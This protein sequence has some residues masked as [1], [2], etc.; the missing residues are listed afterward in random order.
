M[1]AALQRQLAAWG[2]SPQSPC[3]LAISGGLDSRVLLALLLQ[4][5][6]RP[7][8]AHAHF[9]LRGAEAEADA[10]FVQALA[11][12]HG[13]RFHLQHFETRAFAQ[14]QGLSIQMAARQLRYRF[15]AELQQAQGYAAVFTAHHADDHIETAL[16]NWSRAASLPALAGIPSQRDFYYRPLLPFRRQALKDYALAKGLQW[17]EDRS[18]QSLDYQRNALRHQVIPT[19]RAVDPQFERAFLRSLDYLREQYGALSALLDEKLAQYRQRER[20][21]ERLDFP[22]ALAGAAYAKALLRYWLVP[23]GDW[24]WESLSTL[25]QGQS[26]RYLQ[27]GSWR[28]WWYRQAFYLAPEPKPLAPCYLRAEQKQIAEPLALRMAWLEAPPAQWPPAGPQAYL[29]AERLQFPLLLRPWQAGDRFQPLGMSGFKKLSDYLSE[30]KIP[31]PLRAQCWVLQSG[32][33]IVW[34]L[35]HQIDERYKVHARAKS[36]YFV[37]LLENSR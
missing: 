11:E 28:L 23:Y 26:G 1:E 25:A 15:F 9:G 24:D 8:L 20:Q 7:A 35:G 32:A 22:P 21:Y 4:L 17:R 37:E 12:E 18:N 31:S 34:V 5:G 13:L 19:W 27:A 2:L 33:D 16:L 29:N 3:L 30:A 10:Q 36:V 6:Y 14:K